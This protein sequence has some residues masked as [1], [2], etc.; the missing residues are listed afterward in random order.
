MSIALVLFGCI[1]LFVTPSAVLLSVW[2]GVRC[3]SWP[4]VSNICRIY[5]GSL[6]LI[7]NAPN[8]DSAADDITALIICA[9]FS[10]APLFGGCSAS[11]DM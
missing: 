3:Y 5:T 10:T 2:S 9:M 6:A 11:F 1:L 4:I 8:S 7:Y